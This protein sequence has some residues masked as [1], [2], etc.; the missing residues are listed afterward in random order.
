M[1]DHSA[2]PGRPRDPHADQAILAAARDLMADGGIENLTVEGTAQ[3]AG[4]AKTTVYRRYP[5][6]L[7][8]AVAAVAELISPAWEPAE[9][10]EESVEL[11]LNEFGGRFAS[12]SAQHAFLSVAAAAANDPEG[13]ALF[14]EKVLGP[15]DERSRAVLADACAQG[16]ADPQASPE[17]AFDVLM[18][19]LVHRALIRQVPIDEDFV[20]RYGALT[21]FVYNLGSLQRP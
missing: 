9:T 1:G 12:R 8:L 7:A 13:H 10:L 3:L 5:T 4:V 2:R 21:R 15:L 20:K 19:T 17:F 14:A 16:E 11:G 6:K 18:G